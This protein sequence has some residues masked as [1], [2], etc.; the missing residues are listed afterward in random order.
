MRKILWIFGLLAL[1]AGRSGLAAGRDGAFPDGSTSQDMPAAFDIKEYEP[2][3]RKEPGLFL[4]PAEK[5]AA[6]QLK[7]ADGLR[8]QGNLKKA[9]RQYDALVHVWHNSPEAATAQMALARLTVDLK[10]YR[11]AFDEY[12]YLLDNF[13]GAYAYEAILDKQLQLANL[14]RTMKY[15]RFLFLPGVTDPERA[16]PLFERIIRNAP[17]WDRAPDAKLQMAQIF[18][19]QEDYDKAVEAYEA[20]VSRYA[21]NALVPEAVYSAAEC[22]YK[23][24]KKSDRDEAPQRRALSAYAKFIRDYPAD[25]HR[26]TA[27]ARV[28]ELKAALGQ[29]LMDRALYY[30]QITKNTVAAVIAYQDYLRAFP[31]SARSDEVRA[32]IATLQKQKE[33]KP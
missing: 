21:G 10:K 14:L 20:L 7:H 12:Q 17:N 22:L 15:G 3:E 23:L 8:Q 30:D 29:M 27:E 26:A 11:K 1:C 4:R 31:A 6:A 33:A 32:R 19:V 16:L 9:A 28:V 18:E 24:A 2:M 5:T 25:A 13:S